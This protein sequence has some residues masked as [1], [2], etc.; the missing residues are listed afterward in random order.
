MPLEFSVTGNVK[1]S[2]MAVYVECPSCHRKQSL[3]NKRCRACDFDIH[4]MRKKNMVAYWI[5]LRYRG[6][7]VWER[8][9]SSLTVA[10]NQEKIL[11]A[12]LV[13][14]E[15]TPYDKALK[16]QPFFEKQFLPW[17]KREKKSWDKD[18]SRFRNHVL[19]FFGNRKMSAIKPELIEKFKE[20]RLQ[21]GAKNATVNR[22]L[23]LLKTIFNKAI[24]WGMYQ[25]QN[26]IS[27]TG[28]LP[29][30]NKHVARSLDSEDVTRLL[31][32]LP[33]ET[34]PIFEFAIATGI[35]IGNI[36]QMKWDQ[37]DK[38]HRIIHLPKTKTGRSIMLPLTD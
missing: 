30:N 12:R 8:I 3:E 27:M 24:K 10:R 14:D 36:L 7:Q 22:D 2:E 6:R 5:Y 15:Y 17:S 9:G 1:E 4:S 26:P 38:A 35:R 28:M 33:A 13:N 32:Q 23:A 25:G 20:A 11:R 37:I 34:R 19:P 16:L 31:D 29:E 21:E 18:E